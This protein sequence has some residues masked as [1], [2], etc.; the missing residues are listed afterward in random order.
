MQYTK[1]FFFRF[2]FRR[3]SHWLGVY[4][5]GVPKH[6]SSFISIIFLTCCSGE[7]LRSSLMMAL[8]LSNL[9]DFVLI[10]FWLSA[11]AKFF[12]SELTSSHGLASPYPP[13][14]PRNL[15][16]APRC[17]VRQYLHNMWKLF[18]ILGPINQQYW[19]HSLPFGGL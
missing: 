12:A 3:E 10:F 18:L 11:K 7:S 2:I 1:H 6:F 16:F 14:W 17:C 19:C 15:L 5:I 4:F 8:V 9:I 13:R